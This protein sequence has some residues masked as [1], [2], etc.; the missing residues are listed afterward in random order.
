MS[1]PRTVLCLLLA[2]PL[3]ACEPAAPEPAAARP[4]D[5]LLVVVDTLRADRLG[6]YGYHRPTS[7]NLDAL[8]ERG[9]VF[10][11]V[12]SQ[13]SW[14]LPSMASLLT[15]R[16]LLENARHLPLAVPS[17]AERLQEAGY[18]TAA[19]VGN[20]AVSRMGGF[21][22]GFHW[23]VDRADTGGETWD[24]PQL[25]QAVR[26]W[27]DANP[28][29]E[30]PR[31]V[32]LH[33]LD[34]HWPYAPAEPMPLTG[35]PKLRDDTLEVWMAAAKSQQPVREHFNRDRLS[36]LAD[37]DAYDQEVAVA[38]ASIG[39]LVDLLGSRD[40][41][42]I[43]AADHGEVLWDHRH[44]DKVVADDLQRAGRDPALASLRDVFF[45][46]HSYH[47]WQELIGTPLIAAGP[48]LPG[49]ARI[50]TPVGNVDIAP[51]LLFAAGLPW[52]KGLD[53]HPLQLLAQGPVPREY[54]FSH[55]KEAT[56]VRRVSDGMKLI[57]PTSTGDF[58]G[59]PIMLFDLSTDPHERNNRAV[60]E[61]D[62][63]RALIRER[64]RAAAA[65]D[66]FDGEEPEAVDDELRQIMR[67]LGYVGAGFE[68]APEQ[69]EGR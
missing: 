52:D 34:P 45:R 54:I 15:G 35:A 8:A 28:V 42:V 30:A 51:T 26:S 4:P 43:L 69:D 57:F 29:G 32:Y 49:G 50:L 44:H 1:G 39:R 59:M 27:L 6:S 62:A 37:L 5:L 10:T 68:D 46:D 60:T 47:M 48:G 56:A 11:D 7:P 40:Q 63:L 14:T 3:L 41:L 13:S 33:Y 21:D 25:E 36:I 12:M 64:E 2:L 65:F 66:L 18:E 61:R 23:W 9:V 17:L 55:A 53:G 38:D 19:F 20:P 31:F 58:F 16:T 67:E 22:R 24:A